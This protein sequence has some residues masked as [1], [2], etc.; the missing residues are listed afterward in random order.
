M[1]LI[2]CSAD[3]EYQK[4]GYCK[5]GGGAPVNMVRVEGCSYYKKKGSGKKKVNSPN[6]PQV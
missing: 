1:N 5:L 6:R 2:T 4:D 3:C